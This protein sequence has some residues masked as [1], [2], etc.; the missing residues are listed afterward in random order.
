MY[1]YFRYFQWENHANSLHLT[2]QTLQRI[3]ERIQCKTM[4]G[5]DG[6]WIDWKYLL[7][8]AALLAR[9]RYTLQY[10]Y[11][12]VYYMIDGPRKALVRILSSQYH[13]FDTNS[14]VYVCLY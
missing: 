2:E 9:C 10:T 6:T 1:S 7:D 8:A 4:T 14:V 12:Y 5:K 13:R 3:R 11:P